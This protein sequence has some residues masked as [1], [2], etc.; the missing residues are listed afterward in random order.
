MTLEAWVQLDNPS[1][2]RTAILKEKPGNDIYA[3]YASNAT[4]SPQGDVIGSRGAVVW[5]S[6]RRP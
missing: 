6:R 3:L 2:W 5:P 1:S 4:N